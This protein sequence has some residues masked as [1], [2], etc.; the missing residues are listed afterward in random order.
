MA[1][2]INEQKEVN[3]RGG[4][5]SLKWNGPTEKKNVLTEKS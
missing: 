3:E 4:G 2:I 5:V 1:P